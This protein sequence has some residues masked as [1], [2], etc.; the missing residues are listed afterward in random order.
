MINQRLL[1]L[2]HLKD[3]K[4]YEKQKSSLHRELLNVLAALPTPKSLHTAVPSDILK[5]LVW[6]DSRG[7]TKVHRP[8]CPGIGSSSHTHCACPSRLAAGTV[9]S[10]IGKLRAI[11]SEVGLGGNWDDRLGIGNPVSHPS[12]TNYLKCIRQEQAKSRIRPRK[13]IPPFLDKLEKLL[14]YILEHMRSTVLTPISLYI[15]S[16]DLC[17]FS[18]DFFSGDR[19]SDLGRVIS[20]ETLFF[21][22]LS[23]ILFNQTFGKTLRE[24]NENTF[25]IHE[26]DNEVLCPV[27]NFK[28]YLAICRLLKIDIRSGFLFR[29]TK[30]NS[31]TEEAFVGSAVY[32]LEAIC[33]QSLVPISSHILFN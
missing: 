5:F 25:V 21:P 8:T 2:K 20:K 14:A 19:S 31:V 24:N 17:F 6:K 15:F 1:E 16:R 9:D 13:A 32:F 30:G 29:A 11:F 10:V 18:V 26:C 33:S 4:P 27:K 28:R 7:R 12:I 3:S 22:D 23:G